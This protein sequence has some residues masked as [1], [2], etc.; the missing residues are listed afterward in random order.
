MSKI[1][2]KLSKK[3]NN[4][5]GIFYNSEDSENSNS[6]KKDKKVSPFESRCKMSNKLKKKLSNKIY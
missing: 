4:R 3:L 5:I 1:D 2:S 6:N